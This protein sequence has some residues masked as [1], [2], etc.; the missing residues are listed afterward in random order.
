M[1]APRSA[2]F[3]YITLSQLYNMYFKKLGK[4]GFGWG[5]SDAVDCAAVISKYM[6]MH[7]GTFVSILR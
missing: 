6:V 5:C 4:S 7:A 1:G 3:T 2:M